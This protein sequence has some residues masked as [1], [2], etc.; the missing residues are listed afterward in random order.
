MEKLEFSYIA[1]G[2]VKWYHL[3][4]KLFR[5][6]LINLNIHPPYHLA[7]LIIDVYQKEVKVCVHKKNNTRILIAALFK[8][9]QTGKNSSN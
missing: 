1:S 2:S 4:G 9:F 8:I 5:S 7:I 3:F 6:F